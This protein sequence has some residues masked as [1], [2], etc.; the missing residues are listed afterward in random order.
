MLGLLHV[1]WETSDL[2][3]GQTREKETSS[4]LPS[5]VG[6]LCAQKHYDLTVSYRLHIVG[7]ETQEDFYLTPGGQVTPI[8]STVQYGDPCTIRI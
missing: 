2:L 3:P 6:G 7:L 1:Q 8:Y 5:I 4:S